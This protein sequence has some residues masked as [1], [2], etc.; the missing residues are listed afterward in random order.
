MSRRAISL[1]KL[2]VDRIA[3]SN[4]RILPPP[5]HLVSNNIGRN[6][7]LGPTCGN[8]WTDF[9]EGQLL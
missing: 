6:G 1:V 3:D 2:L 4:M 8:C 9:E 7:L 5:R